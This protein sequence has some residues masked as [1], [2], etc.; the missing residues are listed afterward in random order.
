MSEAMWRGAKRGV[1]KVLKY[2]DRRRFAIPVLCS[3]SPCN[4]LLRYCSFSSRY[5]WQSFISYRVR[6]LHDNEHR[7]QHGSVCGVCTKACNILQQAAG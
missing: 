2:C 7:Q 4:L 3:A 6:S 5:L 1:E